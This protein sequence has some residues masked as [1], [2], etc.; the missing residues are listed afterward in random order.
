M[1]KLTQGQGVLAS[2]KGTLTLQKNKVSAAPVK[3]QKKLI[4]TVQVGGYAT[5]EDYQ[6]PLGGEEQVFEPGQLLYVTQ[7][8]EELTNDSPPTPYLY[9]TCIPADQ[10]E[11]H[12]AGGETVSQGLLDGEFSPASAPNAGVTDIAIYSPSS[13]VNAPRKRGRPR[14]EL[15][16]LPSGSVPIVG[17][18][19]ALLAKGATIIESI[20][21][22]ALSQNRGLFYM[23]GMFAHAFHK[24]LWKATHKSFRE[25]CEDPRLYG[26]GKPYGERKV[27]YYI[28]VYMSCAR[29]PGF[30]VKV[31]DYLG[32]MKALAL[33]KYV[34]ASNY[35][36][37]VALAEGKTTDQFEQALVEEYS[38]DGLT[39][40]GAKVGKLG[41]VKKFRFTHT[42]YEAEGEEI[43]TIFNKAKE[44]YQETEDSKLFQRIVLEWWQSRQL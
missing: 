41:T 10:K 14:T 1:K 27:L 15:A 11:V 3:K 21:D 37:L 38:K 13:E 23:G 39:P 25:F 22:L 34:T 24:G 16:V 43:K 2:P 29:V 30:D 42:L 28:E 33:S 19:G 44:L 18:L 31:L 12:L 4:P 8:T 32:I 20:A 26:G 36:D 9:Y 5:F 17:E 40:T 7:V 6:E 35:Q